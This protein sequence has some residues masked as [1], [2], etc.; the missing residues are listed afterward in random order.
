MHMYVGMYICVCMCE[1]VHVCVHMYMRVY[2]MHVYGGQKTAII[3][4]FFSWGLGIKLTSA[5]LASTIFTHWAIFLAS[6]S[7]KYKENSYHFPCSSC[8]NDLSKQQSSGLINSGLLHPLHP[9]AWTILCSKHLCKSPSCFLVF[10][11]H[12]I[13]MPGLFSAV[14]ISTILHLFFF[15][16]STDNLSSCYSCVSL[17][18]STELRFHLLLAIPFLLVCLRSPFSLTWVSILFCMFIFSHWAVPYLISLILF[19]LSFLSLCSVFS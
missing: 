3:R 6:F 1:Y 8:F 13:P 18:C 10:S 12:F 14:S 17:T 11:I 9:H 7:Q 5:S 19:L 4:Q 2:V 16:I 15:S